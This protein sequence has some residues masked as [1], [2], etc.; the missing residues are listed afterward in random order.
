LPKLQNDKNNNKPEFRN[1]RFINKP[2][3]KKFLKLYKANS[4]FFD[5]QTDFMHHSSSYENVNPYKYK[6][7][8][9]I[10]D[11]RDRMPDKD[12]FLSDNKLSKNSNNDK[13][14]TNVSI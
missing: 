12:K 7:R 10:D 3:Y 2:L 8:I 13:I 6:Q 11:V 4:L 9:N 14:K 1:E 5:E